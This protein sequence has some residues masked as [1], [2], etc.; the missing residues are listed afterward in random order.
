MNDNENRRYQ[1]FLRVQ[2]F[3]SAR[4]GDF[5]AQGQQLFGTLSTIITEIEGH[6][7]S[8]VS[9]TGESRQGTATRNEAR[10]ALRE[11]LE[12][13]TRTA[14]VMAQDI[15]GL[16]DKFR[17]PRGNNDSQLLSA[18]RAYAAD[19]LPL[20]A[21]FLAHEMPADFLE[22]LAADIEAMEQ[23]MAEQSMG[24]SRR[25]ASG[26]ALDDAIDRGNQVVRKL[27]AIVKNK[28]VN[29]RAVLAEWASASHT[30]RAP[31]RKKG[32]EEGAGTGG[33]GTA[34]TGTGGTSGTPGGS[35]TGGGTSGSGG[36]G[37]SSPPST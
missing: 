23:S 36:S 12:A 27:D 37:G 22:D 9:G 33:T 2:G 31:R 4:V 34:G 1:M 28:Y 30:E 17:L 32:T 11:D 19:A 16:D 25:I 10:A 7:A 6:A 3:G 35:G 21:Q 24:E 8:E 15:P 13:I 14:R 26:A 20:K 5:A 29:N 18:G